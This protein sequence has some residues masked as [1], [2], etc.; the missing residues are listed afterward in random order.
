[1]PFVTCASSSPCPVT[2][3]VGAESTALNLARRLRGLRRALQ[4]RRQGGAEQAADF[5]ELRP[6]ARAFLGGRGRGRAVDREPARR[7]VQVGHLFLRRGAVVTSP[8]GGHR[9]RKRY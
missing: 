8:N 7:A 9:Q 1:M 4:T 3:G 5:A 2:S 6:A